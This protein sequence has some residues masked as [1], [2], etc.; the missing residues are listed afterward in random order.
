MG[1]I[2]EPLRCPLSSGGRR[3]AVGVYTSLSTSPLRRPTL[4]KGSQTP[5]CSRELTTHGVECNGEACEKRF[6]GLESG[7]MGPSRFRTWCRVRNGWV[8]VVGSELTQ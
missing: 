6:R 7:L 8:W 1:C 4:L 5:H 2:C 3:G